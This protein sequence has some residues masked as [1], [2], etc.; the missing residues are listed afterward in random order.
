MATSKKDD[1]AT[2]APPRLDEDELNAAAADRSPQKEK[3]GLAHLNE[4]LDP[5][6]HV[7]ALE[8]EVD[9]VRERLR[10]FSRDRR[11]EYGS[12][13][14]QNL[15]RRRNMSRLTIAR[16]RWV[17][18]VRDANQER[19]ALDKEQWTLHARANARED[20]QAWYHHTFSNELYRLRGPFWWRE[21][22]LPDYKHHNIVQDDDPDEDRRKAAER[23]LCSP[24]T[25]YTAMAA[26]MYTIRATLAEEEYSLFESLTTTGVS[27]TK[28]P[29]RSGRPSQKTFQ[30]SLVQGDMYLYMY[31]TWKGKRTSIQGVELASVIR[32]SRGRDTDVL[33]RTGKAKDEGKYL[34]LVTQDRSLDLC[35]DDEDGRELWWRTMTALVDVEREV[36]AAA[37][38]G[39]DSPPPPP[40]APKPP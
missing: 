2:A 7:R 15:M 32:I 27:V 39:A 9:A 23:I 12:Y 8:R 22:V 37:S 35:F 3:D 21:A 28:H 29:F 5:V 4:E 36:R 10:V 20:L 25:T 26:T 17:S 19:Q 38:D 6:A 1:A 34:S 14:V 16:D 30:L 40:N 18:Y 11:V 24:G 13:K 33:R 31:L